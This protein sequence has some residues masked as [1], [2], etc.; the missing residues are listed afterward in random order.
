MRVVANTLRVPCAVRSH[1]CGNCIATCC[2]Q[3]T[4]CH[5][6]LRSTALQLD[7]D[8]HEHANFNTEPDVN[9]NGD[10]DSD[11][12]EHCHRHKLAVVY[13]HQLW[14]RD[15]WLW[16][17]PRRNHIVVARRRWQHYWLNTREAVGWELWGKLLSRPRVG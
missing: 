8:R 3:R 15:F 17:H 4:H 11:A 1:V 7:V 2:P 12:V 6:V 9:A 13:T 16:Y 10:I 5:S 14:H